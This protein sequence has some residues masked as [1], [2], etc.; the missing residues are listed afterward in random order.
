VIDAFLDFAAQAWPWALALAGFLLSAIASG[1]E[2]GLYRLNRIRLHLRAEAGN[3][4]ARLLRDLLADLRGM[5]I[6]CLIGTNIGN[7]LVTAV[8]TVLVASSGW[9]HTN[10]G[11]QVL[12]TL[13]LTPFLFVFAEVAPKSIFTAE[14]DH[15]LYP[16]ARPLR[17]AYLVL[18]KTGVVPVLNGLSNLTLRVARKAGVEAAEPFTPR[19]RLRTVLSES[20]AEGVITG[21]QHELVDRV[22]GLRERLVRGV[23]IPLGRVASVPVDIGRAAFLDELRKHSFSRLPVWQ[24]RRE[25]VIG[26]VHINDVLAVK[27]D[28]LDLAGLVQRSAV[29]VPP[30]LPVGQALFRLRQ[31]RAAMAI[32]CDEKGRAL[33]VLT[34][35]DL[36]EEI[37]GELAAW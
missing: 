23:M 34:I 12:A 36:V 9:V 26:I 11:V 25:N 1:V 32:V 31:N 20:A 13:I 15:W 21:Y 8:A 3:P 19:Q 17:A 28:G 18:K 5:I 16:M 14:A 4:G 6:V 33:G 2:T 24:G 30:D 27:G 35:K 22:L 10:F 37:V 7:F 29:I